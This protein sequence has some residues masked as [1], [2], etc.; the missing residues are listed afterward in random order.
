LGSILF[1]ATFI[2]HHVGLGL[3][4][5]LIIS[6]LRGRLIVQHIVGNYVREWG[7][8]I[9]VVGQLE[10][11]LPRPMDFPPRSERVRVSVIPL[12]HVETVTAIDELH[13]PGVVAC[14]VIFAAVVSGR[15]G[16]AWIGAAIGGDDALACVFPAGSESIFIPYVIK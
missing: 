2:N 1:V 12:P 10:M 15:L 5:F 9:R 13:G 4:R 16:G 3:S 11:L 6:V 8:V 14:D 7:V